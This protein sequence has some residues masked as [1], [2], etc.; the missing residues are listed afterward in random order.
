MPE[1]VRYYDDPNSQEARRVEEYHDKERS[2]RAKSHNTAWDYYNGNH[3]QPL[4]ADGTGTND[5]LIINL[6]E[7]IVDKGVSANLGVDDTGVARGVSFEIVDTPGEQ[8]FMRR[9]AGLARRVLGQRPQVS[10]DQKFLDEVFKANRVALLLLDALTNGSVMGHVF[11]KIVPD[12]RE[13]DDG[14][15]VPRLINLHASNVTVFWDAADVERVLWYRIQ[16]GENGRRTRQDIVRG[17]NED[18]SESG[19]WLIYNF[20][21][22]ATGRW[23]AVGDPETWSY[24]WPPIIDWKNL[25]AP[26]N[27]YGKSD[28]GTIGRLNDGVNFVASNTQRILK[29]HAHPK[30][31]ASGVGANGIEATSIDGLWAIPSHEAKVYNLELQSDLSSSL[32]FIGL[33]WRAIFDLAREL[34]PGT[35]ADK[36]GAITNFGL[37][38]LFNDSLSKAG[39]K[40]LL[41]GESLKRLCRHLLELGGYNPRVEINVMWPDP[42][43]SD[44]L[45]T[46]QALVAMMP[47]GL[48]NQ[49]ALERAGFDPEQ[50]AQRR[51]MATAVSTA[52]QPNN[53]NGSQVAPTEPNTMINER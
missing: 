35:V 22:I 29:H 11:I 7:G 51:G 14:Q 42:L 30:T 41:A 47:F 49:T 3:R 12:G 26:N 10:A 39:I 1:A 36:L 33:L 8:G 27:Y 45:Q 9:A 2:D 40:R 4:K 38:V 53:P 20:S 32:Q 46:A 25:P 21:E 52:I 18:G 6:I 24:S 50:E 28:I 44:L 15:L 16:Y 19:Q 48:S 5:N 13:S 17:T 23:Q 43:P 37:R 31:I 34:N